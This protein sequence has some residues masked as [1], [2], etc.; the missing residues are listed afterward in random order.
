M[1]SSSKRIVAFEHATL[2]RVWVTSAE[3]MESFAAESLTSLVDIDEDGIA[4]CGVGSPW[5]SSEGSG[6][7]GAG[8]YRWISGATGL[9]IGRAWGEQPGEMF[10]VSSGSVG[11][12]GLEGN[13]RDPHSL[14]IGAPEFKNGNSDAVGRVAVLALG[15]GRVLREIQGTIPKAGF[16][17]KIGMVEWEGTGPT[18][19][20]G[21]ALV[22]G[23]PGLSS[24]G[25]ADAG[26]AVAFSTKSWNPI[27]RVSGRRPGSLLGNRIVVTSVPTADRGPCVAIGAPG[28]VV[29]P[30][31]RSQEGLSFV[32]IGWGEA[33]SDWRVFTSR[34]AIEERAESSVVE[35]G[36]E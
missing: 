21:A 13:E 31:H 29:S 17:R 19:R 32:C 36:G 4:D 14:L 23:I 16:G 28:L 6:M 25:I 15:T 8:C 30:I 10:G 20:A 24:D 5:A 18:T 33:E 34:G 11:S 35:I 9:E 22:V 2:E 1:S 27:W 7:Q 26:G 12:G 3:G